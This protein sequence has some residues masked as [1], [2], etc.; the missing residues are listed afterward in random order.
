MDAK[1]HYHNN[2][3]TSAN[4][5]NSYH[6][7]SGHMCAAAAPSPP[8]MTA[9]KCQ[10]FGST[11]TPSMAAAVGR[12]QYIYEL[13][14]NCRKQLCDLLDADQ[15]WRQLGGQ[16]MNLNDTSLTLISH[17]LIRN[18]SPTNEL[19][20]K[21]ETSAAK[22][23]QLFVFLAQMGHKRAMFILRPYVEQRLR[24]LCPD[25]DCDE[26]NYDLSAIQAV[27]AAMNPSNQMQNNLFLDNNGK[28]FEQNSTKY[29]STQ[30][31][32]EKKILNKNLND[33]DTNLNHNNLNNSNPMNE[34]NDEKQ[35]HCDK[36]D[37]KGDKCSADTNCDEM[38]VPYKELLIATDDFAKDRVLGNGGFGTVYKGEWKGT[39]VAI[40]RLKGFNDKSQ[41]LTELRVLNRYRIDN[42]LPI[43]GVSLDGVEPCLVYQYMP[44]GSLEDR[45]LCKAGT[46]PLE[47]SQRIN[48]GEGIA[49]ALNYLHTLKGNAFVHGDV[50][51]ANVLLDPL[52]EPK[53]GD[54][55][56]AR[57]V[58]S[59]SGLYTH[60]TVSAVHGT[61]VYLPFEYLRQRILSPAVDVYSYGI[62]LL[63]MA[64]GKRAFDGKRLLID[65]IED[66]IKATEKDGNKDHTKL[67]D[68]RI[69]DGNESVNWFE[70]LLD[71]GRKC[72]H[73]SKNRRPPMIQVLEY[74]NQ[75]KTSE[76]IRRLSAEASNHKKN[77]ISISKSN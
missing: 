44:N 69:A 38:E 25:V 70:C 41:A 7:N 47:W 23:S 15:S 3:N 2:N 17:A 67:L 55:G 26:D 43:Y 10:S 75:Y 37:N 22:V 45:L 49:R 34:L 73:R 13:P 57:Q 24:Q 32:T 30:L 21:W 65:F 64:T 8:P 40:K 39:N 31:M 1:N 29:D 61:S 54:F 4:S 50:K 46:K 56:L 59:G 51:S 18:S 5:A 28:H 63:E 60:C 53:L 9:T 66:E 12:V 68:K 11:T 35:T 71:L 76:R 74:Y 33:L 52:F 16:Y 6:G 20:T 58:N 36:S 14:Y 42:I 27:A 48:I 62:V 77:T 19:L 72:A